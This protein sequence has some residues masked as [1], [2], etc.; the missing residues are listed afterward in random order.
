[1]SENAPN[2]PPPPITPTAPQPTRSPAGQR[3]PPYQPPQNFQQPPPRSS[4]CGKVVIFGFIA[5]FVLGAIGICTLIGAFLLVSVASDG[6]DILSNERLERTQVSE[7]IIGGNRDAKNIIAVVRIE[8]M[9][10][11]DADGFIARQIRRVKA[12]TNVKAV[13]LRVDSP[14]GTMSGSDYYLHLLNKMKAER[15]IPV[16]V[17]MGSMAT[18]GGYFVSMAGDEIFAE[19]STITGSIGVMAALFNAAELLDKIGIESTPIA[20]GDYKLMGSF[21]KP[22]SEEERVIW[23]NLITDN[24]DRFQ[25][26]IRNARGDLAN[27]QVAWDKMITGQIYTAREAL[28]DGLIDEIGFLDDAIAQAGRLAGLQEREYKVIQYR[29]QLSFV[30]TLLESRTPNALLSGQTLYEISTPK[31]YLICPRVVPIEGMR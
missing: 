21:M 12:D 13:V 17:S 9:I 1:M 19:P 15:N 25:E 8:G 30:E 11:S 18:S 23:Q 28:A 26:V 16:V 20:S 4:G 14:G 7:R 10:R 2:T 5:L 27:N 29:P 6:F 22:M 31:I 3:T 24:F